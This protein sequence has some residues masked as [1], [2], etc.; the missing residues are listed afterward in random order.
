MLNVLG[1]ELLRHYAFP[2]IISLAIYICLYIYIWLPK[3]RIRYVN[4]VI[5]ML[6]LMLMAA[7]VGGK[8]T[9]AI[10]AIPY[11][12]HT[13]FHNLLVGGCV[14]YGGILGAAAALAIYCRYNARNFFE[15]TDVF[16]SILPLGQAIG[17]IGCFFN[18]CCY[19]RKYEGRL[20]VW[21]RVEGVEMPV[22]PTWFVESAFCFC[23][24]VYFAGTK[25]AKRTGWY[26]AVYLLT[27]STFRFLIEFMR[28]DQIRGIWG[29]VSTSQIIS[30]GMF[31][32]GI[33][34]FIYSNIHKR[35][36]YMMKE[37]ERKNAGI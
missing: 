37:G 22:F 9:Y 35:I 20:A 2:I 12:E 30:I 31:I 7:A 26:T 6:I 34:A 10:A 32:V 8:I 5:R 3:Y 1:M 15:R 33:Y 23:L 36:N 16:L 18:G 25:R 4:E 24:F 11:T 29:M 17:R 19:G 13:F 14:F 21:Y 27:Y 28:G